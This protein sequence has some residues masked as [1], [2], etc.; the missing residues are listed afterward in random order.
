[1]HPQYVEA[2]EGTSEDSAIDGLD[3]V[4]NGRDDDACANFV[5]TTGSFATPSTWLLP[6]SFSKANKYDNPS[7]NAMG[8][9]TTDSMR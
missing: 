8:R 6:F 3:V 4:V 1:M 7:H 9:K 2:M 5:C